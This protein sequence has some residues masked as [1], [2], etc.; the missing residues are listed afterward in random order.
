MTDESFSDCSSECSDCSYQSEFD[1][2][3]KSYHFDL[4]NGSPVNTENFNIVHYNINSILAQDK[5]EQLASIS[6]L[7]DIDILI[8]TE[9]KI[10]NSIPNNIIT[11]SGY[12]E[13]IRHDRTINGRHGGG[14]LMYIAEHL[15]F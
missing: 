11:L 5:L 10:D 13:P 9:S 14:V 3:S 1:D 12:H 6:K 2:Q 7:L 8:I 4:S 15:V